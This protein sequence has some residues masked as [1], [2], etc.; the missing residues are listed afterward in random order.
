[1]AL[2]K[3]SVPEEAV[4]RKDFHDIWDSKMARSTL[5][6]VSLM[7]VIAIPVIF[8]I[9]I[10][11]TPANQINGADKLMKMLPP[12]AQNFNLKQATFYIMTNSLFPMFFLMIPLMS[13]SVTAACSF[14]GKREHGTLETLLLTP[15]KP[16]QLFGAKV[17]GCVMLSAVITAIS[18]AAFAI[19]TSVGDI[20]LHLPFFFSWSWLVLILLF[21]PAVTVLG[22][23]FM[24]LASA[25]SKS[26]VEAVQTSGYIV[27]PLIL[28]FLGE[29]V[30]L[31]ALNAVVFLIISAVIIVLD[32]IIGEIAAR[33]FRMEKLLK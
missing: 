33:S 27:I 24:V 14:V 12:S 29:F 1:M 25:K 13:S 7:L 26:Y 22:V 8:L 5:I 32:V 16:K 18:F 10:V 21:A 15:M 3:L 30:G 9:I 19:V 4:I 17:K 31:F 11:N 6:T 2:K 23:M 28:L 20:L